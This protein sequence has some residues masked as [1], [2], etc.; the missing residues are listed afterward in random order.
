M[1]FSEIYFIQMARL[2]TFLTQKMD[3][4]PSAHAQYHHLMDSLGSLEKLE[5]RVLDAV[6]NS[7]VM[8]Q[9]PP[10]LNIIISWTVLDLWR[11][12]N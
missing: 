2:T 3:Q 10:T 8:D 1:C 9:L 7:Q 4:L 5:L 12:P 6:F 11:N